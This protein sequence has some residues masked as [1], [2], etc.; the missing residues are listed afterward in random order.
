M[1]H[2]GKVGLLGILP[3]EISFDW[4]QIIFKGLTL[5]ASMAARYSRPG[6]R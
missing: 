4:N 5:K 2:G 6:T 3:G 1:T